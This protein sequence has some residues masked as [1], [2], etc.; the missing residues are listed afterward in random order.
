VTETERCIDETRRCATHAVKS[1]L[2]VTARV[3]SSEILEDHTHV[4]LC[5]DSDS[6]V[7]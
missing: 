2:P 1:A 7:T 4:S 3:V 5:S 6:N